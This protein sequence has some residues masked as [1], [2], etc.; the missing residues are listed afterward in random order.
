M[1]KRKFQKQ[2]NVNC[3]RAWKTVLLPVNLEIPSIY[4]LIGHEIAWHIR[5]VHILQCGKLLSSCEKSPAKKAIQALNV[6]KS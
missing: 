5:N 1:L 3:T 6:I 4:Y 2:E